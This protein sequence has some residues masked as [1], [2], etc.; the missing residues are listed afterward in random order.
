MWAAQALVPFVSNDS[1]KFSGGIA[2]TSVLLVV[3]Y[4]AGLLLQG[5]SQQ[6][7]ETA[8]LWWWGGFP[9]ARWLLP[10]ENRLSPEYK[11]DLSDV[12]SK[13]FGIGLDFDRVTKG[14]KK[15]RLKRNQEIFYRCYR[16]V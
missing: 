10:E 7:T 15:V 6:V 13:T 12:I 16:A 9:S 1:L 3:G 5:V 11:Q 4:I 14:N 2:E 8:L